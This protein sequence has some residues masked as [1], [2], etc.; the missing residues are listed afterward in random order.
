MFLE[1]L[2]FGENLRCFK[3]LEQERS[4][5]LGFQGGQWIIAQFYR[6]VVL[7]SNSVQ[8]NHK[9]WFWLV[10]HH[11][12]YHNIWKLLWAFSIKMVQEYLNVYLELKLGHV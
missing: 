9:N 2:S 11:M 7:L 5:F 8:I 10:I 12:L 1:G 6:N 3:L 4:F